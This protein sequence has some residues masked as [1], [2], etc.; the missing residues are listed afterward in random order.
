MADAD[1]EDSNKE[2]CKGNVNGDE[3]GGQAAMTMAKKRVRVAR[4]MVTRVVGDEE[5]GGDGGNMASNN[6]DCVVPV[7]VQQAVLYSDSASASLDKV[8][9][10]NDWANDRT[11]ATMTVTSSCRPL[12]LRR[13]LVLLSPTMPLGA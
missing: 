10:D 3:G 13:P 6:D 5:G 11:T 1:D 9:N 2:G 4:V 8:G 7:V 12:M